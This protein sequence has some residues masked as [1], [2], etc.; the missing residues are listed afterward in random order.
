MAIQQEHGQ[1]GEDLACTYLREQGFEI[2]ERNWRY[3]RAEVDII[4]Q[5]NGVLVFTEVKVRSDLGFGRPEEKV[6]GKKRGLL[7][8]AAMAYMRKI[9]YE[10]EI[11][12]DI[13]AIHGRPG[14]VKSVE[15]F[16]DAFFPGLGGFGI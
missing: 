15:L 13:V 5:E 10:W 7:V 1:W 16:R 3:K 14:E 4:S 6:G 2:L 12:F 9:G 11:R 8:E